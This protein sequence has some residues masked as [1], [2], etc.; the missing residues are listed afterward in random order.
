MGINPDT[1]F[2]GIR[3][4]NFMG[5]YIIGPLLILNPPLA[6]FILEKMGVKNP[7]LAFEDTA[8]EVYN[9]RVS[10]FKNPKIDLQ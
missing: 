7:R 2:A 9:R 10:E 5:T 1:K 8:M 3:K 6:K 4:N